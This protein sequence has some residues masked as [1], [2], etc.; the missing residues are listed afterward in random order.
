MSKVIKKEV[1]CSHVATQKAMDDLIKLSIYAQGAKYATGRVHLSYTEY[2]FTELD[3]KYVVCQNDVVLKYSH[4]NGFYKKRNRANGFSIAK[5]GAVTRRLKLWSN[6][7]I[8]HVIAYFADAGPRGDQFNPAKY[9]DLNIDSKMLQLLKEGKPIKHFLT[10][11]SLSAVLTG[12]WD[13]S[14]VVKHHMKYSVPEI[15]L[16]PESWSLYYELAKSINRHKATEILRIVPYPN[17]YLKRLVPF[18]KKA[19]SKTL[20]HLQFSDYMHY[21]AYD[22]KIDIIKTLD[23]FVDNSRREQKKNNALYHMMNFW[24]E[25]FFVLP[26]A[27][28]D[29]LFPRRMVGL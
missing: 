8:S 1:I 15:G 10:K 3:D 11:G 2:V 17:E 5:K 28:S 4:R 25:E 14:M 12:S 29:I 9:F 20:D 6:T 13:V 24:T 22:H 16:R 23:D 19:S 26:R 21:T 27:K 18:V 7:S